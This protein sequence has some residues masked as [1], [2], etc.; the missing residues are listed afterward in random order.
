M[1]VFIYAICCLS[2]V[3]LFYL[4]LYNCGCKIV[5]EIE[6]HAINATTVKN[7][8]DNDYYMQGRYVPSCPKTRTFYAIHMH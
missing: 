1:C 6:N 2:I 3:R 5:Y 7:N 8:V 4:T